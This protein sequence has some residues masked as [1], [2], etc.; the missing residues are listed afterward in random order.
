[1]E[2]QSMFSAAY[3]R[4]A[5]MLFISFLI[6]YAAMYLNVFAVDHIYLS[7]TRLY[8][9][10]LMV[11]PMAIVMVVMMKSMYKNSGL[12]RLIVT[13]SVVVFVLALLGL[14]KQTFIADS[15]YMR[16]MIS[17]HSSAILTSSNANIID[18]RVRKLA[19]GIIASQQKEIE[20]MKQLLDSIDNRAK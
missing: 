2:Q 20:E 18:P 11:C 13:F 8:M 7:M 1:M 12:N 4:L 17:H 5:I 6:M 15:Q 9:T 19:D 10:L 14:R 3:K 16:G